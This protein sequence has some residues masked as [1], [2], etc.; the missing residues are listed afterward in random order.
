MFVPGLDHR[1]FEAVPLLNIG[2][3]LPV[4]GMTMYQTGDAGGLA[5]DRMAALM[6][7]IVTTRLDARAPATG[8]TTSPSCPPN[9][10]AI[11]TS[12]PTWARCCAAASS[13][14]ARNSWTAWRTR[15]P[16]EAVLRGGNFGKLALRVA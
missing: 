16:L 7:A 8:R 15:R 1:V 3:R 11:R 10:S 6:A 12:S 9:R 4:R 13:V 5:P 14:T 2:A